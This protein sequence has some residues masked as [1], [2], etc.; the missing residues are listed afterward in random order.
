[1]RV[2]SRDVGV[3]VVEFQL[4]E[5]GRTL[6]TCRL[7]LFAATAR[8]ENGKERRFGETADYH[9]LNGRG[10]P[11]R[12]RFPAEIPWKSAA[13]EDRHR[14]TSPPPGISG[15][16]LHGPVV[17]LAASA[18]SSTGDSF[19]GYLE[20]LRRHY[21]AAAADVQLQTAARRLHHVT[22]PVSYTHLTL[23][24]IYSV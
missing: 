7:C 19:P 13:P 17:N 10:T 12:R 16:T 21:L 4:N 22:T 6:P 11:D 14:P 15:I 5:Y 20:A 24:T 9:D 23:P 1:M 18:D 2:S 3:G 8:K